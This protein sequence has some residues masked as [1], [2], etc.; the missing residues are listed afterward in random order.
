MSQKVLKVNKIL[1]KL[2]RKICQWGTKKL[3]YQEFLNKKKIVVTKI[4]FK[5]S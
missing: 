4:F 1:F 3:F 5:L 2:A